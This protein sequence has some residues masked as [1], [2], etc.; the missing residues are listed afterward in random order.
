MM[1]LGTSVNSLL[2]DTVVSALVFMLPLGF[3]G[4]NTHFLITSLWWIPWYLSLDFI[5]IF[6]DF[7]TLLNFFWFLVFLLFF[8]V[9][10][11]FFIIFYFLLC[12]RILS[13]FHGLMFLTY[14]APYIGV[15]VL[16]CPPSVSLMNSWANSTGNICPVPKCC[17]S[18]PE[19]YSCHHSF[20]KVR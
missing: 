15:Q 20:V 2:Q 3:T 17:R 4:N 9:W 8:V 11:L 5:L 12:K 7:L 6:L 18:L 19:Y 10:G 13:C 1:R 14:I 16:N